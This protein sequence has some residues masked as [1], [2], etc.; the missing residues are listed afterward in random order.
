M[1]LLTRF[2]PL[3]TLV[4][5]ATTT[6]SFIAKGSPPQS[7]EGTVSTLTET[8]VGGASSIS[9][10]EGGVMYVGTWSDRVYRILPD[11][12]AE[13]FAEGLQGT[14][15][16]AF[17]AHGDLLQLNFFN[18]TISRIASDGKHETFAKGLAQPVGIV[19][20]GDGF[21]VSNCESNTIARVGPD[22]EVS[23][24][25]ES[26]L[27]NCP[28]GIS[29]ASDGNLYVA[30]FY[31]RRLLRVTPDGQVE[32]FANVPQD[33]NLVA[34]YGTNLYITSPLGRH[35]Y[36][37]DLK[38]GESFHVAGTGESQEK[39]GPGLEASF[40]APNGIAVS[41]DG[42]RLFISNVVAEAPAPGRFNIRVVT[43]P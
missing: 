37:V 25:A 20:T 36:R 39:D 7:S 8:L 14:T 13:V 1:S 24:L 26:P 15:G 30:N 11:G 9:I 43:L 18:N 10:G 38:T 6:S 29:R 27:F 5:V 28:N 16:N 42:R 21:W 3:A 41:P 2:G 34:S 35:V 17:D 19:T 32:P 40:S 31:D 23:I 33:R 12:K 4:I 22:G